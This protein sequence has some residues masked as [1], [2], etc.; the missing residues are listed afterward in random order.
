[1]TT[2]IAAKRPRRRP[3]TVYAPSAVVLR[4]VPPLDPPCEE[5]VVRLPTQPPSDM[6][7]LPVD[8]PGSPAPPRPA[9]PRRAH[10]PTLS[11]AHT[12]A[13]RFVGLCVEIL[14]GYRPA[15]QLRPLTHPQRFTDISDQLLRRTVRIRMTPGQAARHGRLVRV[16]RLLLCQ[17]V[18]G[19]AEAAVVLEQGEA[20]WAMAIRLEHQRGPQS[21]AMLG[22]R[23]TV[24]QV[25]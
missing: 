1:M 11:S 15:A 19:I 6:D 18:P 12:A 20:T 24:L 4:P 23:C 2:T 13:Q 8:W 16:R 10:D 21:S 5:S 25:V 7:L 9:A 22:W 14:N 17:P 3:R